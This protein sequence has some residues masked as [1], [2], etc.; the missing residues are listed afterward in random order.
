MKKFKWFFNRA[1]VII[2]FP[3][4]INFLVETELCNEAK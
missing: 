4:G 3:K 2:D 1:N